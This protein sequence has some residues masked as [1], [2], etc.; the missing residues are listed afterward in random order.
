MGGSGIRG[1]GEFLVLVFI[2]FSRKVVVI[3]WFFIDLVIIFYILLSFCGF[4]FCSGFR[5]VIMF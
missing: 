4:F 1:F 2:V 3:V 5:K